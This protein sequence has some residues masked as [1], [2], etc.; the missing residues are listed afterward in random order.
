MRNEIFTIVSKYLFTKY[1]LQREKMSLQYRS[2]ADI[3]RIN[4]NREGTMEIMV[5]WLGAMRRAQHHYRD[6]SAKDEL[7]WI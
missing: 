2:L 1:S 5:M 3:T 6:A 7:T 4:I